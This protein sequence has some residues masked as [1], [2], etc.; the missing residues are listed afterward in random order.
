MGLCNPAEHGLSNQTLDNLNT[1][2]TLSPR[3]IN[4]IGF[5]SGAFTA[6]AAGTTTISDSN[7]VTS[8][9]VTFSPTNGPAGLLLATKTCYVGAVS[10]GAFTFL[11]SATA[12][13]APAGTETFVYHTMNPTDL[14]A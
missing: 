8:S 11:V 1:R 2:G 12:A 3:C 13:G 9:I 10:A 14:D 4:G 6:T 7:I 5:D